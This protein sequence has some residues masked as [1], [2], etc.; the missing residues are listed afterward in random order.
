MF[1][2]QKRAIRAIENKYN[3]CFYDKKT[4]ELP[5]HTKEIFYRNKVL[6]VHNLIAKNCIVIMHRVYHKTIPKPIYD[7][8]SNTMS[9]N[10]RSR[11]LKLFDIP[12]TRLKSTDNT[13]SVQGPQMYNA[14]V[15]RARSGPGKPGKP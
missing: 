7:I 15:N 5:C 3:N 13:I 14:I 2:S 11:D 12:Y 1:T 6:T 10:N 8:F 4:G 9:Q